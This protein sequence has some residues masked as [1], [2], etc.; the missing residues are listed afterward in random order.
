MNRVKWGMFM[1]QKTTRTG[2]RIIG[3]RDA[4]GKKRFHPIHRLV[5]QAYVGDVKNRVVD[6]IDGNLENNH[7]SNLRLCDSSQNQGN[8]KL[9]RNN[10]S[11]FKGVCWQ[12]QM[13]KWQMSCRINGSRR[14]SWHDTKEEAA[15]AYDTVAIEAHGEFARVNFPRS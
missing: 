12:N 5:A 4:T 11:G 2:Y 14:Y 13:K 9:S 3:L 6:H 1:C 8:R 7:A 10:T 15:R